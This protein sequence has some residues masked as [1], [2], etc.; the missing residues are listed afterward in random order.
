MSQYPINLR[1][2]GRVNFAF[3]NFDLLK[4][5]HQPKGSIDVNHDGLCR[6][7]SRV[8]ANRTKIRL[9]NLGYTISAVVIT[10]LFA[11]VPGFSVV[12]VEAAPIID[13]AKL[14]WA[15]D[16][17]APGNNLPPLGR[18]LFDHLFVTERGD[19]M[20]YDIPFPFEA[21]RRRIRM[22]TQGDKS[23][24]VG[25]RETLIPFSRAL[26]R[27]AAAPEFF[28]YPRI[29]LAVDSDFLSSTRRRGPL[30]KDRLYIGYQEKAGSLEVISY[31][32]VAGRF[33]FQI[34]KDYTEGKT[35]RVIY[36]ERRLCISCHQNGGPI[37]S[38]PLWRE[39]NGNPEIGR[40]ILQEAHTFHGVPSY[41]GP[42]TIDQ[43]RAISDAVERANLFSTY[44]QIWRKGCAG[45]LAE[46]QGIACRSAMLTAMLQYKL[47]GSRHFDTTS[48]HYWKDLVEPLQQAWRRYWPN[49]LS[50]P[51]PRVPDRD[52]LVTGVEVSTEFDPLRLR[53]SLALWSIDEP[54][55]IEA[56]I[57][58]LSQF[59]SNGDALQLDAHLFS[60]ASASGAMP[61]AE[62]RISLCPVPQAL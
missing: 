46:L 50:I 23:S 62:S 28:K 32:E 55:V 9:A 17:A 53:P 2:T 14:V 8:L 54:G 37:F 12:A 45:G 40:R 4:R 59:I 61:A 24:E 56:V 5:R 39:T 26:P 3:S 49:G 13:Q 18:S 48:K 58:G 10:A 16:A 42:Q 35:P 25:L 36:A 11:L 27:L 31:N 21:L 33:E 6:Y 7:K 20:A 19:S 51:D 57:G 60:S 34:V 22:H 30:L 15:F 29:V 44:Q 1:K 52:P 38:E 43:Q 41:S 47:S